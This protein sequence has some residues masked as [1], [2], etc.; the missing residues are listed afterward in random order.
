ME[1]LREL[2]ELLEMDKDEYIK[3]VFNNYGVKVTDAQYYEHVISYTLA[4]ISDLIERS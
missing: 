2:K 1:E 3:K 4:V